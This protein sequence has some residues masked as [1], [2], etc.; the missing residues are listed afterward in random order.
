MNPRAT[1]TAAPGE[2]IANFP[3]LAITSATLPMSEQLVT[4]Q[5]SVESDRNGGLLPARHCAVEAQLG[6]DPLP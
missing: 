3:E 5:Q 4:D 1:R 6:L 2:A